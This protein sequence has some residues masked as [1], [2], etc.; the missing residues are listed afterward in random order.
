LN[1]EVLLAWFQ[2]DPLAGAAESPLI[3]Q[4][5][6]DVRGGYP[7]RHSRSG[8]QCD[9]PLKINGPKIDGLSLRNIH[10]SP[11]VAGLV[12][13]QVFADIIHGEKSTG[14]ARR[15]R[16]GWSRPVRQRDPGNR[17]A[18][19][20]NDPAGD[21]AQPLYFDGK[22]IDRPRRLEEGADVAVLDDLQIDASDG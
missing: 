10:R 6:R 18:F 2:I 15:L 3:V 7:A 22:A 1:R 12:E 16:P 5:V 11:H 14:V 20:F 9:R 17:T 4:F 21:F 13:R 19:D 8:R